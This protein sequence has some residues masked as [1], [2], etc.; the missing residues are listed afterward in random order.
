MAFAT[1]SV[2]GVNNT[3][4]DRGLVL[5]PGDIGDVA[6]DGFLG[7]LDVGT[8]K[9][10]N[11]PLVMLSACNTIDSPYYSSLPFSGLPKSFMNAGANSMLISLWNIDSYSAKIFNESLFDKGIFTRSFYL[12]DSIQDSMIDMI[13]SKQHSHPYYWAPY[14]YLGK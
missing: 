12:S 8:M 11:D 5:T 9:F 3:N 10:N 7:S 14:I 4:N 6:D 13:G 1:H 2:R